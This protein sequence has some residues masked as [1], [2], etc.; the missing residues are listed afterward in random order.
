MKL[1][2]C[3]K[4]ENEFGLA[5]SILKNRNKATKPKEI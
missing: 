4:P 1:S 5:S 2:D 3:V